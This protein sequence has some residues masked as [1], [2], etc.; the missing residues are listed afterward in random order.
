MDKFYYFPPWRKQFFF[1]SALIDEKN[2]CSLFYY[3]Y[4]L[5]SKIMWFLW[6]KYKPIRRFFKVRYGELPKFF[7]IINAKLNLQKYNLQINTGT[8]G[9]EQKM[10]IFASNFDQKLFIKAGCSKI[11][12][13]LIENETEKLKFIGTRLGVPSVIESY[14]SPDVTFL[15]MEALDAH[16]TNVTTLNSAVFNYISEIKTLG[17]YSLKND[18]FYCFAHG[19]CCPWNFLE[20]K[21]G[22][23]VLIDWELSTEHPIGYDLITYIFQTAFLLRPKDS[24]SDIYNE[25]EHW[26]LNYY[27]K[28]NILNFQD[29]FTKIVELK[30]QFESQKQSSLL[31]RRWRELLCFNF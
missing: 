19:D 15:V 3:P 17:D 16:K 9:I 21:D 14:V 24:V 12:Q 6:I 20:K 25:N 2:N 22:S 7:N 30:I 27:Q 11:A 1:S 26:I 13:L 10:T 4:I 28:L 31:L 18:V 23:L 8:I 5:P 29:Y